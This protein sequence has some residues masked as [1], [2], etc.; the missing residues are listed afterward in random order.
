MNAGEGFCCF[1]EKVGEVNTFDKNLLHK[2][3]PAGVG[4]AGR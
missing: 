2:Q 4:T 3:R 1:F